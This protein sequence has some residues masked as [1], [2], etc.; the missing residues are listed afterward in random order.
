M[1]L[2]KVAGVGGWHVHAKDFTGRIMNNPDAKL[3]AVWDDDVARGTAWAEECGCRF[4]ANYDQLLKNPELQGV[5]ITCQTT[6][7]FDMVCRA[8]AAGKHVYVEKAPFVTMQE[9]YAAR[10]LILQNGVKFM[11]GSPIV[12]PMHRKAREML[13]QGVLGELVSMR[14]RTVHGNGLCG[15][16]DPSLYVWDCSGGG[17]MM[18]MGSHGVHLLSW[19]AGEPKRAEAIF[20]SVSKAAQENKTDDNDIMVFEFDNGVT[21]IVETGWISPWYQ[22]G[23]DLYGTKGCVSMRAY[24]MFQC[25]EDGIWT[26]VPDEL[27]PEPEQYPLNHWI[28]CI[29]WDKPIAFDG[30]DVAVLMTE[31]VE[32]AYKAASMRNGEE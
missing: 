6:Q 29:K 11:V 26:R 21:G 31:M 9:A 12:K 20:T 3:I 16:Q 22:Y 7:H 14:Y 1:S 25:L 19:F 18:D 32:Q 4:E 30:I 23:F 8:A 28:E 2:V 24:E 13:N 15:L 17:A 5:M 27:L 10:E